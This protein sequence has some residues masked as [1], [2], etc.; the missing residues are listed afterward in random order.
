MAALITYTV[1]PDD[2]DPFKVG[3]RARDVLVWEKAGRD[4]AA[5]DLSGGRSKLADHYALAYVAGKR[6]GLIEVGPKEFEAGY[7]VVIADDDSESE[8]PDPTP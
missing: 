3:A 7:D 6:Q 5:A 2:G 8:E 4:R 1:T